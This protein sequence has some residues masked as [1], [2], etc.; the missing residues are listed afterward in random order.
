MTGGSQSKH[1]SLIDT[2]KRQKSPTRGSSKSQAASQTKETYN[3]NHMHSGSHT[4]KRTAGDGD[5]D[6]SD[7]PSGEE[8]DY[9]GDDRR[10]DRHRRPDKAEEAEETYRS[11]REITSSM[12]E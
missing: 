8:S 1:I 9:G 12:K 11:V 10:P 2:L 3:P 5:P 6:D 4:K 7:D